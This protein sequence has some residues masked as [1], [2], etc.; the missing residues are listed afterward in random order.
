MKLFK[1][2]AIIILSAIFMSSC[3][4]VK[5]TLSGAK[6]KNSD[7]FLVKKKNPLILPPDFND[8]PKP[9]KKT[10]EDSINDQS[11]DLSSVL[12]KSKDKKEI[13]KKQ[14]QSLEKSISEILNSN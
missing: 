1:Y 6:K 2:T 11:I 8:L 5:K 7:E 13:G 12:T 10:K 4:S 9:L 3:N 14:D